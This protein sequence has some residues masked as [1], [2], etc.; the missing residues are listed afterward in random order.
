VAANFVPITVRITESEADMNE[1]SERAIC[2]DF[3]SSVCYLPIRFGL[4]NCDE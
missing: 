3:G 2:S 4:V 1:R